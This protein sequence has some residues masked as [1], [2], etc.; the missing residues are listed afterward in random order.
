MSRLSKAQS[1]WLDKAMDIAKLS[2]CRYQHGAI[3]VKHNRVLGL[4]INR[5]KNHPNNVPNP[6]MQ[7]GVHA[8]ESA[9]KACQG[10]TEGATIYVA[11]RNKHGKQMMSK[12]CI[13]CQAALKEAGIKKV[14]Y[15]IDSSLDLTD[16]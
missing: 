1:H 6:K 5:D 8:E 10:E 15:T 11:R 7:A 2:Q 3:I 14:I 4:G 16:T 13:R 9:I 12:P